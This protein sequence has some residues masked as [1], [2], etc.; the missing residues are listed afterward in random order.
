MRVVIRGARGR[1]VLL[2]LVLAPLSFV[3]VVNLLVPIYAGV[4]FTYLCLDELARLRARGVPPG[5]TGGG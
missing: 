4:A 5:A 1:L 2:G 3:P